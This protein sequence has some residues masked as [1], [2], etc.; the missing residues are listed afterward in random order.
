MSEEKKRPVAMMKIEFIQ[1]IRPSGRQEPT[2][3]ERPHDIGAKAK[4]LLATG[5]RLTVERISD[6]A[7]SLCYEREVDGE[8]MDVGCTVCR[9]NEEV[10]KAVDSL[11]EEMHAKYVGAT[12]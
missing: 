6:S 4:E 10:R 7:V 12:A 9:N 3:I 1:F 2:W 11:I 5:G 8:T